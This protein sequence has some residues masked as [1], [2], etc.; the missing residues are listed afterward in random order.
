MIRI[1]AIILLV[2]IGLPDVLNGQSSGFFDYI[3]YRITPLAS[4]NSVE[5]DISPLIVEGELYFSS[6]REEF[7]GDEKRQEQNAMFY[8]IYRAEIDDKGNPVT[9]RELVPGFGELFHEGPAAW[10]KKTGELFVTLNNRS[11]GS[12]LSA[13]RK[14]NLRLVIMK[15]FNGEWVI[16]HFRRPRTNIEVNDLNEIEWVVTQ[17]FPF[18]SPEYNFAHPAISITG[19]TLVF[20][21]DMDGGF[22]K[23]DLYMSIREEGQW[24]EPVNLG[25][26]INTAGN[27]MFPT[28]G[29]GG[30]LLFSSDA[31]EPNFGQLDIYYI[32]ISNEN[33]P[34]NLGEKVNSPSDDF[35]LTIHPSGRFGYFSSN[36]DFRRKD[37][38]YFIEL[39]P[40]LIHVSG[41]VI[42]IHNQQEVED[43]MVYLEDCN[44]NR[45]QS[46]VSGND[47]NFEFA[48]PI[49]KCYQVYADK[50]GFVSEKVPVSGDGFIELTLQQIFNYQVVVKDFENGNAVNDAIL[51]CND[52]N[53]K[54]DSSGVI[55]IEFDSIF[56][57]PVRVSKTGYFDYTFDLNPKRFVPGS[58]I[59]DTLWLFRKETG[60]AFLMKSIDFHIDM[61][62]IMPKSEP[63]LNQLAKL[64]EDNP[65]LQIEISSH[66]DSRLEDY[67]NLWI[68]Q[69]RADSVLEYLVQKGIAKDRINAVGYGETRLLNRCANGVICSEEEHL[70]NRRTEFV[71][72]EY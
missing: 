31:L 56:N 41:K 51:F 11:E 27:E 61:W 26:E 1:F 4:I 48:V 50:E 58:E 24:S 18:Y 49:G 13:R 70:V 16:T 37:D 52:S 12:N 47:G 39:I 19:D 71:I 64:M 10:C 34:V 25:E 8:D 14:V 44:G 17:D 67:Y 46:I 68:S 7:F 32:K 63:E 3:D 22:G 59:T 29:P 20:S 5:S 69:K 42:T 54:S 53:W 9:E 36:R 21:S 38:I 6:V 60:R 40:Q 43:A 15:E 55:E 28:F 57:C 23:S 62:M 35:G 33:K 30:M 66:T 2:C 72:L 45:I 65:T